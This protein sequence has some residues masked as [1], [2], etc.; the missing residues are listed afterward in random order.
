[1]TANAIIIEH[2]N[3]ILSNELTAISQYF[4][5]SKM[6]GDWGFQSLSSHMRS[7][8]IDEMRHAD[9]LIDRILYLEGMPDLQRLGKINI[10]KTVP[11]MMKLDLQL[12]I[13]AVSYLNSTI[14]VCNE[15]NDNGTL[16]LV[17]EILVAE[18]AH[19]GWVREQLSLIEHIGTQ[20]YLTQHLKASL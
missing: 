7:E 2:L 20:N 10:G 18:E 17:K 14:N 8:A 13:E 15:A 19:I 5:H 4:V 11:E 6:V 16:E 1:M 9:Q 3:Q 12:E